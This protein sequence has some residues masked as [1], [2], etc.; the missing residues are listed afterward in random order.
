[1]PDPIED[2]QH[3]QN[4]DRRRQH[5]ADDDTGERLLRLRPDAR[6]DRRGQ[7]PDCG[8]KGGHQDRTE[9]NLRAQHDRLVHVLALMDQ[10]LNTADQNERTLHRHAE[11]GE[12]EAERRVHRMGTG[13][14]PD[15]PGE[16]VRV[17]GR[18]APASKCSIRA[19]AIP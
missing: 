11:Q 6:G 2:R 13:D 18:G 14:H 19:R 4:Q 7:E 17:T 8:G 5:A 16:Q 15:R 12:D 9:S 10:L 1:M 3:D